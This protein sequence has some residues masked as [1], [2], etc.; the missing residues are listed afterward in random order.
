MRMK[1]IFFRSF[2]VM[3]STGNKYHIFKEEIKETQT[4]KQ[5]LKQ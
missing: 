1:I 2:T 4:L 5:C 3:S